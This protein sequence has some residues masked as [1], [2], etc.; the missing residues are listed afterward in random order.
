MLRSLIAD[1]KELLD[2]YNN[3]D[4]KGQVTEKYI[5]MYCKRHK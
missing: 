3:E 2:Q 4:H 1:D 5:E